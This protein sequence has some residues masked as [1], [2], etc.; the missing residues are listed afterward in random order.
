MKWANLLKIAYKN[1]LK[2]KTR[3]IL[4]S[5]GIIIGVTSVVVMVGIGEGTQQN[6]QKQIS[7]LGT[8]LIF[9]T[10]GARNSRGVNRG[11]G[12]EIRLSLKDMEKIKREATYINA[13]SPIVNN[14]SQVIR[15]NKNWFTN[16]SGVA[17]DMVKI[18]ELKLAEG[19]FFEERD[20]IAKKNVAV[21]GQTIKNE[22]FEDE[23][24]IGKIIRIGQFPFI[25]I[26]VLE[27]KGSNFGMDQDDIIYV[28]YSTVYYKMT[29][30]TYIRTIYISTSSSEYMEE[31]QDEIRDI[32]RESHKLK[33]SAPD[34][35][36]IDNQADIF[37]TA[38]TI[39]GLIT[40]L[41]SAIAGVSLIVG[42]I[43]IM[44]IM[45]VSVTER[46]KE[47]GL[48]LAIGARSSD[49]LLQFLVEAVAL[50][51][52]GGLVGILLSSTIAAI[53]NN[54]T[55]LKVVIS[56]KIILIAFLFS[57]SIGTFFGWYPAKKASNLNPIEALRYE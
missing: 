31:A 50:S 37:K 17:E 22:L 16:I 43:G 44:N 45:L 54:F 35:F 18:R 21:I 40:L 7:S 20:V 12:T 53:L 14:S 28:P 15:G 41:L 26:G 5:L 6:V 30:S 46:T 10:S 38:S 55:E 27:N 36:T 29:N 1:I 52:N 42:G 34:D 4:T 23:D 25:I 3:S 11:A 8:N 49:V 48:R 47:I 2:N 9:I 56:I 57:G 32:L 13:I 24:P 51:I 39:T 33:E 19:N